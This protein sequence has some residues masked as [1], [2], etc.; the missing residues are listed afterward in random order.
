MEKREKLIE[1][2][3]KEYGNSAIPKLV[4]LLFTEDAET[5]ELSSEAL[6]KLDSC[7]EII[8]RLERE[9]ESGEH[10][11]GIFYAADLLGNLRCPRSVETLYKVL[12]IV[13][14][15]KEAIV[16]YGALLKLGVKEAEKYLLYELEDDPYMREHLID[17]GI[18]L[19]PSNNPDVF[20]A[21]VKKA[22]ENPKLV[23]VLQVMCNR[24]P[25]FYQMLPEE[26]MEKIK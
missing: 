21:I 19:E 14:D 18:A 16:V 12:E 13:K 17:I 25:E 1:R 11:V 22:K 20:Q 10:N 8:K 5:S 15:E 7:D 26:F 9:I 2:I 24:N 3:V 4:D 6:E 23:D